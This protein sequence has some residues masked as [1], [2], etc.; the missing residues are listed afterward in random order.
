MRR[1][2][3]AAM[4]FVS[5]A[6]WRVDHAG[7]EAIK[8]GYIKVAALSPL[9]VA[10]EKGYFAAEG[11]DAELTAFDAPVPVAQA[12]VSGDVD[13]GTTGPSA[14]FYNLAG[15]GSLRIIAGLAREMPGFQFLL[16]AASNRAYAA[17]L[18]SLKALAGHSVAVSDVGGAAHY[19]LT[20]IEEK[21]HLDPA[22][23]R[24]TPMQG[25]STAIAALSGG[26]V[27][28]SVSPATAINPVIGRGDAKLLA[29]VGDETPWQAGIVYTGHKIADERRATNEK[30][31]RALKKAARDYHDAFTGPGETRQDGPTAPAILAIM[32]KYLGQPPE[33]VARGV[34]YIDPGLRLDV[35]DILHQIAWFRAQAML[36]GEIDADAIIDKNYVVPLAKP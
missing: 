6:W 30:L 33:Q 5:L 25:I 24:L 20:L 11:L 23:V 10:Q 14:A 3:F 22:S 26:S 4:V 9:F 28:A 36:K 32:A 19:S 34:A 2:L 17:G 7:A 16:V 13:Y 15:R 1:M 27:D 35:Q 21:Y 12:V 29:Y 31:L 18:T 8:I